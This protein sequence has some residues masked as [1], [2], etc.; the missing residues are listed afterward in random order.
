[1]TRLLYSVFKNNNQKIN[2]KKKLILKIGQRNRN[3]KRKC[4][5]NER[6]IFCVYNTYFIYIY[7]ELQKSYRL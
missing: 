3:V 1:M 5:F 2:A 6:Y 4:V 7:T